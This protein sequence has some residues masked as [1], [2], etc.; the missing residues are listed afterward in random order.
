MKLMTIANCSMVICLALSII[1][2]QEAVG[3]VSPSSGQRIVRS[4][5]ASATDPDDCRINAAIIKSPDTAPC[6]YHPRLTQR[7]ISHTHKNIQFG[8][9]NPNTF[10][11]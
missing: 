8:I 5:K 6:K 10:I 1:V 11:F 7:N 9:N 4:S 2:A 3:I